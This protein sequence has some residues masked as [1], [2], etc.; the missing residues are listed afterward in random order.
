MVM[1]VFSPALLYYF[2]IKQDLKSS[3]LFFTSFIG[4]YFTIALLSL[5]SN[6][7]IPPTFMGILMLSLS[8]YFALL[9]TNHPIDQKAAFLIGII[10]VSAFFMGQIGFDTSSLVNLAK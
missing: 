3:F 5:L 2:L 7:N 1:W 6:L 9:L 4:I 10:V 8:S